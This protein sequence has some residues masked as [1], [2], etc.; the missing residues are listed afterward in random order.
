ML[1]RKQNEDYFHISVLNEN[2]KPYPMSAYSMPIKLCDTLKLRLDASGY[3][4]GYLAGGLT[5]LPFYDFLKALKE[6]DRLCLNQKVNL[7]KPIIVSINKI[8]KNL[9]LS[10][11]NLEISYDALEEYTFCRLC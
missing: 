10:E 5:D 3:L 9:R 8:Y 2:L 1:I 4:T 7:S 11:I 6:T